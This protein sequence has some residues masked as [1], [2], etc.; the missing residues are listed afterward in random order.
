MGY[1]LGIIPAA[2]KST[3]F[4][5]ILKELLPLPNGQSFLKEA[6]SRLEFC[7]DIIL[8]TN[9]SK[10]QAHEAELGGRVIYIVQDGDN[11]ILSAIKSALRLKADYYFFTMPDT[12]LDRDTFSH[13]KYSHFG[14]GL[15]QT[16]NPERFGC[17]VDGKI[18][19]KQPRVI[20]SCQAWGVMAWSHMIG[21][22]WAAWDFANY[23]EAINH[24]IRAAGLET[25]KINNYHDNASVADYGELWTN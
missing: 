9:R 2:G 4:G 1:K 13:Y 19:N 20:T 22:F 6:V 14:M 8:V 11:D 18:I 23:T 7:D 3:R 5:S 12:Y 16:N 17:L 25:W 15:F 21:D 10:I 24:A